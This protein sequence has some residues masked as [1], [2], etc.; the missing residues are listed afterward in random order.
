MKLEMPRRKPKGSTGKN[1]GIQLP[2]FLSD[3]FKD[4]RDR[5]LIVPA[6]A[7]LVAIVAVPIMLKSSPEPAPPVAPV[8]VDPDEA[9]LEPAVVVTQEVGVRD[10]HDRL[11]ALHQKNPFGNKFAPK[12][13]KTSTGDNASGT[14]STT[15]PT[16]VGASASTGVGTT[17]PTT[18]STPASP[19]PAGSFVIVPRVD[20]QVGVVGKDKHDLK[21]VHS[22]TLLPDKDAP[23][24]MY[25]DNADDSS[26]ARFLVSRDVTKV[27]GEGECKPRRTDCQF[28]TLADGD[29]EYLRYGKDG[30]RYSIRVTD[31]HFVRIPES[32]FGAE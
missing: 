8:A 17:T 7:L 15:P 16:N 29:T 19:Q 26:A 25:L 2:D 23:V 6:I 11:D 27:N 1:A 24:L 32:E 9:A 3:L 31:I 13:P 4:M 22:G 20:V 18:P 14:G 10:F 21:D 12:E 30:K 5:R 28:L